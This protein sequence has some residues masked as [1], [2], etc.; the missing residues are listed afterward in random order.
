MVGIIGKKIGMSQV[1]HEDGIVSPVTIIEA[2]PCKVVQ[3]KTNKN[4]GYN[5]VQLGFGEKPER[6][7]NKPEQGHFK[8]G[9]TPFY[10]TL[11]EFKDI[12]SELMEKGKEITVET[13]KEGDSVK[14][15][16]ISKGK[17]FQGVVKRH[18][19]KGGP[20]T[21]GQTDKFRSPGSIGQS[22][23]PSRVIKGIRMAGRTGGNQ[24]TTSNLKIVKIDAEKNL[25]YI[26]GAVAGSKNSIV[27]IRRLGK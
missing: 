13:F 8:S 10:R 4:E 14:V 15:T 22:S 6:L 19:F 21:H 20:K 26:K 11:I 5:S 23:D 2:G 3:V 17:G 12:E 18:N 1:F 7:T 16:G 25:L 27:T 9:G 24:T